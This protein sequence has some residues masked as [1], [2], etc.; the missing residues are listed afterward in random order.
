VSNAVWAGQKAFDGFQFVVDDM[1]KT[2]TFI[3]P[4]ACGNLTL[5]SAEPSRK[6]AALDAAKAAEEAKK[7]AEQDAAAKAAAETKKKADEAARLEAERRAFEELSP[8]C[9]V[10]ATPAKVKG[11]YDIAIDGTGATAGRKPAQSMTVQII[12]PTGQPVPVTFEGTSQTELT[13]K[14][15]FKGTVFVKKPKAGTYTLRV[16][17]AAD[18]AKNT[19]EATAT[20]PEDERLS[21]FVEGDFGKERRMRV[22]E[23]RTTSTTAP[24]VRGFCAPLVGFQGG[25]NYMLNDNWAITPAVGFAINTD[26]GGQSSLFADVAFNY[27]TANKAYVGT[28]F[29]I[30]DFNHSDT[31][32]GSWLVNFGFR[33]GRA[34]RAT[35]STCRPVAVPAGRHGRRGQQL[36]VLG[37]PALR[38][39]VAAGPA[40]E[41]GRL[42]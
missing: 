31:V 18:A 27:F 15:P 24:I 14:T 22:D 35:A 9:G 40:G 39:E 37:R 17:T 1:D 7:R 11:G 38:V 23:E 12:G 42:E 4:K 19:C 13:L 20:V 16:T 21:Y 33:C 32:T 25:V 30:W 10:T 29:G 34:R 36:P 26:D 3:V 8:A 5:I 6:K 41:A 2:Y 28:G